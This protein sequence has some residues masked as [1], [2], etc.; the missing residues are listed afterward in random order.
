MAI[1]T[2]K[3]LVGLLGNLIILWLF[4]SPI[5]TFVKIINK[6]TV[7]EFKPDPYLATLLNC[8]LWFFYGLPRVCPNFNSLYYCYF[9]GPIPIDP[10]IIGTG[11]FLELVYI[12]IFFAY[13]S[14]T[15]RINVIIALVIE[16]FCLLLVALAITIPSYR[17]SVRCRILD[18]LCVLSNVIMYGSPLTVMK[19]VIETKSVKYMPHYL[20]VAYFCSGVVWLIHTF[21][22]RAYF[23][24]LLMTYGLGSALGLVQLILYAHYYKTAQWD[25]EN[26]KKPEP[27]RQLSGV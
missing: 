7:G 18:Y 3:P 16:V 11:I 19:M 13:S 25:D 8:A 20:S 17:P 9:H 26:V 24:I 21:I 14:A 10:A 15:K 23:S 5:P 2:L 12:A 27:E 22:T 4:V 6:K 1:A